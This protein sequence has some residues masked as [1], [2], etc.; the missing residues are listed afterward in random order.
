MP[1]RWQPVGAGRPT[2][3][4]AFLS[5]MVPVPAIA[6][7]H[8]AESGVAPPVCAENRTR[9]S[10]AHQDAETAAVPEKH[11]PGGVGGWAQNACRPASNCCPSAVFLLLVAV[12]RCSA[13]T[14]SCRNRNGQTAQ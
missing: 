14:S 7:L 11:K 4:S 13:T 1:A 12:R 5:V 6:R 9:D 8:P 10:V 2:I 3:H